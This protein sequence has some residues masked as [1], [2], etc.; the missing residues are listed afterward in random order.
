MIPKA[1]KPEDI[2][3]VVSGGQGSTFTCSR[4]SVTT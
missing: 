3:I 4:H 1:K 2:Q